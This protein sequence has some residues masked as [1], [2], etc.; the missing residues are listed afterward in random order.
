MRASP[1]ACGPLTQPPPFLPQWDDETDMA[2]LEACVRSV[3]LDGLTWGGSKLVPV[4]YG[5]R[6]LQIQ[7]VVEDDK[8]G[9]DLLEEEITKFEEHV[10]G[11][12]LSGGGGGGGRRSRARQGGLWE[13]GPNM[14]TAL[15]SPGAECRH[16]G[17][18]QDLSP[19]PSP[20]GPATIKDCDSLSGSCLIWAVGGRSGSSAGRPWPQWC[21]SWAPS[22][23]H[24]SPRGP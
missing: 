13:T 11:Q 10:S 5:I 6:K 23:L 9:T 18:Q 19:S 4:G 16:C 8:V 22:V 20:G 2:Q 1:G 24:Q 7:C 21:P 3:Q 17:F 15:L 14:T 12:A